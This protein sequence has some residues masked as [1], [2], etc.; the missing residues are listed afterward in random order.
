MIIV[1]KPVGLTPLQLINLVRKDQDYK[2]SKISFAGRLDPMAR[3]LMMLLVNDEC[4]NQDQ[5]ILKTK[6]YQFTLLMGLNTDTH[7]ILGIL[8][9]KEDKFLDIMEIKNFIESYYKNKRIRRKYPL[10]SSVCVRSKLTNERKPL[11]LWAKENRLSEIDIPEKYSEI[12]NTKVTNISTIT[13][14]DLLDYVTQRVTLVEGDFRQS[15]ILIK[16]KDLLLNLEKDWITIDI[17]T[18][19]G[20]GTYIRTIANEIGEY[21]KCGGI[22]LDINRISIDDIDNNNINYILKK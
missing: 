12:Y 22:A 16:W 6:T 4:K 17:E 7:D 14:K 1:N 11:C 19:V 18:K 15:E 13:S 8:E 2:D 21:F 20:S 5:Y 10:F 3:G 9:K